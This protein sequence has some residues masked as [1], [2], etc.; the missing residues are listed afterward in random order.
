MRPYRK[1]HDGVATVAGQCD[2]EL[3]END[4]LLERPIPIGRS[5]GVFRFLDPP[6]EL[7]LRVYELY[8]EGDE[9]HEIWLLRASPHAPEVAITAV[10][11]SVRE[12]SLPLYYRACNR[13]W[14]TNTFMMFTCEH[15]NGP[16]WR[17]FVLSQC[18]SI[19][20]LGIRKSSW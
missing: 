3:E 1:F 10:S 17:S 6:P 9:G 8:F 7:Q 14:S 2:D 19:P 18:H 4:L 13:F 5:E 16:E 12:A 15:V 11:R 20:G